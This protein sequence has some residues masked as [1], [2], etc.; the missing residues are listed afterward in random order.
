MD[1]DRIIDKLLALLV[2]RKA[3]AAV[4]ALVVITFGERAG[5][6]AAA[7]TKAVVTLAAYITGTAI[8]D[9]LSRRA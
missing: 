3:W 5:L 7:I 9:G 4:A 8:E 2:S 6:D 1:M